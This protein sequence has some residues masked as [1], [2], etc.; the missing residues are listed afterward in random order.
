ML[1]HLCSTTIFVFALTK[2]FSLNK[3]KVTEFL[4]NTCTYFYDLYYWTLS[5]F[6]SKLPDKIC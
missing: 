5:K 3:M 6:S 2:V 4:G 1:K